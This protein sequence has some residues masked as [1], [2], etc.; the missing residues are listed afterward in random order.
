ML[1]MAYGKYFPAVRL[2]EIKQMLE[3][4]GPEIQGPDD[5]TGP[6]TL[7]RRSGR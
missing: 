7:L 1:V 6:W 3:Q 4:I 5:S 2:P